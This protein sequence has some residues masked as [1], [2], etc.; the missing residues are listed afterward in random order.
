MDGRPSG[1]VGR[2]HD[3]Q[4]GGHRDA[5]HVVSECGVA[6]QRQ[7]PIALVHD[8]SLRPGDD[9]TPSSLRRLW[10]NANLGTR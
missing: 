6:D 9:T 8:L 4:P 1:R 3:R 2:V 5:V 10:M 7:D